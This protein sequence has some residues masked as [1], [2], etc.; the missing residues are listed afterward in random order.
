MFKPFWVALQFLTCLPVTLQKQPT[1]QQIGYSLTY[2]PL[3]GL[4]LGLILIS[5]CSFFSLFATAWINAAIVLTAW[6]LL[7]GGLHLDGFADS[8]DAWVGGM[9]D[10]A[11]TLAIMKDPNCGPMGVIAIVL[12][13]LLKFIALYTLI[14]ALQS[15]ALLVSIVLARTSLVLLFLTTP[16]V[17]NVGL[18]SCLAA[19]HSSRWCIL[20]IS[21]VCFLITV[22]VE[23][24]F[25]YIV[26]TVMVFLLLRQAMMNRIGGTTGD[27]AGGLVE[28]VETVVLIIAT[29]FIDH[30]ELA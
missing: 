5:L 14:Q 29:F 16:Y 2:Y 6:I 9:G 30:Y 23:N 19:N 3:V 11:K 17:R 25:F 18:G 27:T 10:R 15:V 1:D 28:V 12:I 24:G 4:L 20:I 21:A 7:T 26:S 8:A 22:F 13:I